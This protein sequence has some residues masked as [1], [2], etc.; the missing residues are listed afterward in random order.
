MISR[1]GLKWTDADLQFLKEAAGNTPAPVIAKYLRRSVEGVHQMACKQGLSVV[2]NK[3]KKGH[4]K[5]WRGTRWR[6]LEC[7]RKIT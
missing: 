3:C 7:R 2:S 4:V 5:V 1:E 6:C